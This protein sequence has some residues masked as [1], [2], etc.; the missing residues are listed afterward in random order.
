MRDFY[1]ILDAVVAC[2]PPSPSRIC[3]RKLC[4]PVKWES[5]PTTDAR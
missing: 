4:D 2:P 3:L 1:E 5:L